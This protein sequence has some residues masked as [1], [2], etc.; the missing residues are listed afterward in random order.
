MIKGISLKYLQS[1]SFIFICLNAYG[2]N[3]AKASDLVFTVKDSSGKPVPEAVVAVFDGKAPPETNSNT[4]KIIQKNKQFNPGVAVIQT[5]TAVNFPNEDSV[6]HHVYSFSP[7]KKFE[8]K[9]YS[10]VATNPVV[11]DKAGVVSLGC[12][13][14]DSMVGYI[15]VVDTPYFAKTDANGNAV[16]NGVTGNVNYQ[17]WPAGRLKFSVEQ[18]VKVDS[19]ANINVTLP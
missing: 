2:F 14:H 10:G 16:I 15:Y 6:R 17:V 18:S 5:G 4:A 11:F 13:I 12:N 7:A 8:L 3:S 1:L 9:L 19:N